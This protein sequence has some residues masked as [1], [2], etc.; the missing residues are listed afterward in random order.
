MPRHVQWIWYCCISYSSPKFPSPEKTNGNCS[1]TSAVGM[2]FTESTL[3]ASSRVFLKISYRAE[4]IYPAKIKVY[5]SIYLSQCRT[6]VFALTKVRLASNCGCCGSTCFVC[7]QLQL[8]LHQPFTRTN[9]YMYSFVP[10]TVNI[11]N[12][13]PEPVVTAPIHLFKNN[14]MQYL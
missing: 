14:V 7:L 3:T 2:L 10:R 5:L 9:T 12:S 8:L 13:L 1:F 4:E 6:F 11:W